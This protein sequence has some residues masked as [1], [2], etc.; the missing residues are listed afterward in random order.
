MSGDGLRHLERFPKEKV[1]YLRKEFGA[2]QNTGNGAPPG[3]SRGGQARI[4]KTVKKPCPLGHH[5]EITVTNK[6]I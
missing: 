4:A 5:R 3:V 2:G 6:T 1:S